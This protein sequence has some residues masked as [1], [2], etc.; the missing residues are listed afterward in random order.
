MKITVIGGA[1]VDISGRGTARLR[2]GDS[3]PG[4]VRLSAGGVGRN[5]AENLALLGAELCFITAVG[6]DVF[7]EYLR[8]NIDGAGFTDARLILRRGMSTGLYLAALQ[9]TG[10]LFTA[11]NETAAVESIG[12][13]DLA[14][15]E[16]AGAGSDLIIADANLLPPALLALALAAERV[17]SPFMADG[18]SAAKVGRLEAVLPRLEILKINRAEAEALAGFPLTTEGSLRAACRALLDRGLRQLYITLGPGGA[19]CASGSGVFF[20]PVL[21]SAMV[22]VN[23][24]GD[25]FAAGAAYRYCLGGASVAVNG[26]FAAACA[27]IT[28]EC[29]DAVCGTLTHEAAEKRAAGQV[30]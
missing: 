8:R 18:V 10:E 16:E 2:E 11:V 29:G 12:P 7:G 22:N 15:L 17:G 19:C 30:I 6:D 24:A 23:G 13:A 20:Q 4:T 1:N 26:L 5:I 27:A 28:T 3:N 9:P 25:A 21:P 14:D